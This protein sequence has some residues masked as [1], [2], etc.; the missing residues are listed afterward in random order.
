MSQ[1]DKLNYIPLLVWFL[2]FFGFLYFYLVVYILPF[3]FG[4]LRARSLFFNHLVNEFLDWVFFRSYFVFMSCNPSHFSIVNFLLTFLVGLFYL[5]Y[6]F[7]FFNGFLVAPGRG[8]L[9]DL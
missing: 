8:I 7:F 4:A 3:I 1:I 2:L 6:F 5:D 9:E